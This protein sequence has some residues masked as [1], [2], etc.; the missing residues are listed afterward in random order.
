MARRSGASTWARTVVRTSHR[1]CPTAATLILQAVD[2]LSSG[3]AT[4]AVGHETSLINAFSSLS[5]STTIPGFAVF[6]LCVVVVIGGWLLWCELI[7]RSVVLT[8]LLVLVPVIVPLSTFPAMRRLGWRLA[9]TFIAVAS[10]KLLIVIALSLG[11]DE[12]EGGSVTV[13]ITGAVTLL[14]ATCTPL[15][16]CESF[17]SS[18]SRRFTISKESDSGSLARFRMHLPH[19]LVRRPAH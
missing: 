8:L 9:E 6:V 17:P 3:A 7:I 16:C 13:A 4:S 18:S 10:S 12:L 5:L 19:P 2:Q 14:L 11:L 1:H 15:S